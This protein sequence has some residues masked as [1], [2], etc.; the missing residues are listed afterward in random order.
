M[1]RFV[2]YVYRDRHLQTGLQEKWMSL[3]GRNV[4]DCV[5]IYLTCTRKWPYFGCTLFQAKVSVSRVRLATRQNSK[6]ALN[7]VLV[8]PTRLK[9]YMYIEHRELRFIRIL[10]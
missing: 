1:N 7:S 9:Y 5:R 10:V 3:K 8:N 4:V 2:R 6:T